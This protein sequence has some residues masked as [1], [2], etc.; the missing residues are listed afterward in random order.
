MSQGGGQRMAAVAAVLGLALGTVA[1]ARAA[2]PAWDTWSDTWVATDG[3]GRR[4]PEGNECGAPRPGKFVGI[5][6]FLWLEGKSPVFDLTRL[7]AA[8][9]AA[10]AYGPQWAFHF[11]GEPLFG[12]YRSDDEF[13]LRKHAQ[14]LADAGVDVVFFDV[15]NALLYESTYLA[16]C[17]VFRAMQEQG[18]RVPQIAFLANS[19][20]EKVVSELQARF[21]ARNLYPELWFRWKGKPLLLSPMAGLAPRATEFFS[22][23]HSWAWTHPKG[24]FGDGRDKWPWL[25]HTP[26]GFGWHEAPGQPE[27]IPVAVAEHPVSNIGRSFHD[28]KQPP[29]GQNRPEAGLYF[30]EQWKRALAVNPELVFVTGWNEWI[31]QRFLKEAGK[32]PGSLCG[33]P[34]QPGDTF[35]VD[36]LDQEFSRDIE[37]MKGG[38]GDHYYYQMVDAIRRYKGAR[39]V[40]AVLSR[41]IQV[42]G[43]FEDWREVSPEF[44]DTLGDPVSRDH[45]G[46]QGQ[47]R[48]VDRTGRNDIVAAKVSRDGDKVGF[49]VRTQAA[50]TDPAGSNWMLLFLNTDG[51]AETG[52]LGYDFVLNRARSRP[53][54]AMLERHAGTGYGWSE[55]VEVSMAWAGNELELAIPRAVLHRE[56]GAAQIDFK[57]ADNLEQD[58]QW[59][60]F[61][62][63]GDAAPNDRF[64]FRARF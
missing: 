37:P 4:L 20:H 41:P 56:A 50:L 32:P 8:N 11:W 35:F 46:W 52:W 21:Y 49:Y 22:L 54:W 10:P 1:L 31:A 51:R 64:S 39:E 43:K 48:F 63:H 61:T 17:R 45:P 7:R 53:G 29:P 25:D 55:P 5:F 40:P 23:R 2:E 30:A 12:Y 62:L 19:H 34:L 44:R 36:T 24:W 42:D 6:Y 57:W 33:Q 27:Q 47:P 9:P 13:V 38:H 26:Q 18:Q 28:G 3:L 59:S 14:M 15:T 58:G 60:D 16:A